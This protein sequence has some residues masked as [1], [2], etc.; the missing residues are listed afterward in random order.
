L[1]KENIFSR[2]RALGRTYDYPGSAEFLHHLC[3]LVLGQCPDLIVESSPVQFEQ[4][5]MLTVSIASAVR[6]PST[7]AAMSENASELIQ[8]ECPETTVTDAQSKL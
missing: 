1:F 3:I 6:E 7:V 4:D 2:V 5:E 8:T